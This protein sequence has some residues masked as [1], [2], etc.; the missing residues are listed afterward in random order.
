MSQ[1]FDVPRYRDQAANKLL[2]LTSISGE[3][4]DH[5]RFIPR[6][7]S[8]VNNPGVKELFMYGLFEVLEDTGLVG[9]EELD[10][11]E[12]FSRFAMQ[13][14]FNNPTHE[15]L[16]MCTRTGSALA[17]ILNQF[18]SKPI[19]CDSDA[20]FRIVGKY[21]SGEYKASGIPSYW[22]KYNDARV[23]A[24]DVVTAGLVSCR[25]GT[26]V[27]RTACT[28]VL[29]AESGSSMW[30]DMHNWYVALS[31]VRTS[32]VT[33]ENRES[34]SNMKE[35][36]D[37]L[38]LENLSFIETKGGKGLGCEAAYRVV[39]LFVLV[40]DD[41]IYVID[42]SILDQLHLI[43]KRW[44]GNFSYAEN[45][46]VSGS[47]R[48]DDG[49]FRIALDICRTWIH[50]TLK[51]TGYSEELP[52][53]MKQSLALLQNEFHSHAETLD[54]G[55]RQKTESLS[56][57]IRGI[58]DLPVHWHDLISGL[59]IPDRSKLDLATLY[60][61]LPSP[62]CDPRALFR[63]ASD[64]MQNPNKAD[65]EFLKKFLDYCKSY[66]L[67]KLLVRM[68][69]G[70]KYSCVE[71]YD[72][73][74]SSWFKACL[75]G[76]FRLPKDEDMGKA[77]AEGTLPFVNTVPTWFWEAS[78]VT[79]VVPSRSVYD[80]MQGASTVGKSEHNELLYALD[81]APDIC[82]GISPQSAFEQVVD[83]VP[84]FDCIAAMAAKNENTKPGLKTRETWSGDA[85]TRE[86]TTTYDRTGLVLSTL[87]DG[88]SSRKAD[89][90]T[91]RSFD[92]ICELTDPDGKKVIMINSL[93][94]SGWSPSGDREAWGEH[95]DYVARITS[96]PRGLCLKNIWHDVLAVLNK[97]GYVNAIPVEKG[98]FQGWTGTLD[99]LLNVRLSLY[100]VREA[101][102]MGYLKGEEGAITAGLIDDAVQAVELVGTPEEQ[103]RAADE[104][105]KTTERVWS[106]M[107]AKIDTV[108]TL[109]SSIKFIFLNRFFCEGSEVHCPMKVY[110]RAD[111]EWNRRFAS[112]YAQ[113]DTVMGSFRSAMSKGA[114]PLVCYV[115]A[116]HKCILLAFQT[117]GELMGY[118]TI[119]FIN[120]FFAP[121]SLGG[122]GMPHFQAWNT[123]E[124]KDS[125][126]MYT[127]I[128]CSLRDALIDESKKDSVS[129]HVHGTLGQ[130]LKQATFQDLVS[131]PTSVKASG[132]VDPT[133]A[134]L[135]TIKNGMKR[136][137]KSQLFK[138]LLSSG[139]D[140]CVDNIC[141]E[142]LKS[143]SWDASV[144]ELLG[145]SLPQEH[146]SA[147]VDRAYKNELVVQLFPFR[148]RSGL[149]RRLRRAN[150]KSLVQL[151]SLVL[152]D[153]QLEVCRQNAFS[154]ASLT[155]ERYYD[156]NGM[157]VENHTLPDYSSCLAARPAG[158]LSSLSVKSSKLK[159]GCPS[160]GVDYRNMYD[161]RVSVG[162][163]VPGKSKGVYTFTGERMAGMSP[164]RRCLSKAAVASAFV[165]SKGGNGRLMWGLV[166][167]LWGCKELP[168]MPSVHMRIDPSASAKR[169]SP[170]RSHLTHDIGCFKNVQSMITVESTG[171]GRY[172]KGVSS[173]VDFMSF[174]TAA[175]SLALLEASCMAS[176]EDAE[177]LHLSFAL[178]PGSIPMSSP[179]L[180]TL[181]AS[182]D[183][184]PALAMLASSV[185]CTL[186]EAVLDE[187]AA[188]EV[189][190]GDEEGEDVI[191]VNFQTAQS[192]AGQG[193]GVI[194]TAPGY[195][196]TV[197]LSSV[198][199]PATSTRN[200]SRHRIMG[201]EASYSPIES[202]D[203]S[204]RRYLSQ[205]GNTQALICV[206]LELVLKLF[207]NKVN[208]KVIR[209]QQNVAS[210]VMATE[211][212]DWAKHYTPI[213]NWARRH[214]SRL[215][216]AVV[217]KLFPQYA[218]WDG[219]V[220][221]L[222]N[223]STKEGD[224]ELSACTVLYRTANGRPACQESYIATA[225]MGAEFIAR[226]W[227]VASRVR[228]GEKLKR[229]VF[230]QGRVYHSLAIHAA[231]N[232]SRSEL[233]GAL[234]MGVNQ[235]AIDLNAGI[236]GFKA[237]VEVNS[238]S[239]LNEFTLRATSLKLPEV[240]AVNRIVNGEE[241]RIFKESLV[242][243]MVDLDDG[244]NS[245]L[246][247]R[248]VD[249]VIYDIYAIGA[250]TK[251][252]DTLPE[253]IVGQVY[254][255][256]L[257][258]AGPAL[259]GGEMLVE[260]VQMEVDE[261]KEPSLGGIRKAVIA[262]RDAVN[263]ER[264]MRIE[265]G[266]ED[267][268]VYDDEDVNADE[269]DEYRHAVLVFRGEQDMRGDEA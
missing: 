67:C 29:T 2:F 8:N 225:A 240:E 214:T 148:V 116:V 195:V 41:A 58:L 99:T 133:G 55:Y 120:S 241:T 98:L 170:S 44:E 3:P 181:K 40:Y 97:R 90:V 76:K 223:L 186:W 1:V 263:I 193:E 202:A 184:A 91:Q 35:G 175:R 261:L 253:L 124:N 104:H 224:C 102:R 173:H 78:D 16:T 61:A 222:A 50:R 247:A 6:L 245:R 187:L 110:A 264:C 258:I 201:D 121:R 203:R 149:I 155:R 267:Y 183:P 24:N 185:Q 56:E 96:I 21:L 53:V 127:Y 64:I 243:L 22:R 51:E 135:G 260:D 174:V 83:G 212:P 229:G 238:E 46:R 211:F 151:K 134:I 164:V 32:S 23:Q 191:G 108:K 71:G 68:G 199:V 216:R 60:Y 63:K 45:Y 140:R 171:I 129:K 114:D 269:I 206:M 204:L 93:D 72:P 62:D 179:T 81:H 190:L 28:K 109:Y 207:P 70:L 87:Y 42:H 205:T 248:F 158:S 65:K 106:Q 233:C 25:S 100:C 105:F 259:L 172:L 255:E 138:D 182:A 34:H 136:R 227:R 85:V 82:P 11:G 126:S 219:P 101:K 176:R 198:A 242:A 178:L 89:Y 54:V 75:K 188:E 15:N 37:E 115:T 145:Q 123:Q 4:L 118:D 84:R 157:C 77:W 43:A 38:D 146:A 10:E 103:Q 221:A 125:L 154:L 73:K 254:T 166:T 252:A 39:N 266:E 142:I 17:R 268:E 150:A 237:P 36:M 49:K 196:A 162:K 57:A 86:M 218:I 7:Q 14:I 144:L 213:L 250:V 180:C 111:K 9:D 19:W 246:T 139:E 26:N 12:L 156:E 20:S 200:T 88:A 226:C 217:S 5:R 48:E 27:T 208:F 152:M 122:W 47:F 117:N 147:L 141:L 256:S 257:Q 113:M 165:T 232:A 239:R 59:D 30:V 132:V 143:C 235:A 210:E 33:P 159:S 153:G 94:V 128:M 215:D 131:N 231:A 80:G 18:E 137:C 119:S 194:R 192:G 74:D 177:S 236:N 79:R 95:H 230:V 189:Y 251:V 52:R 31:F 92:R 209:A 107:A 13:N 168:P 265:S 112:I 69:P 244:Q 234:I 169:I 249:Q 167:T 66:D 228:E 197:V 262:F 161:G 220:A 163:L 130:Q 160:E